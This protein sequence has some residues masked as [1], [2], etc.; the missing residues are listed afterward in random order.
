[1]TLNEWKARLTPVGILFLC[2]F[3][4]PFFAQLFMGASDNIYGGLTFSALI[5]AGLG[6]AVAYKLFSLK[7]L[8][9]LELSAWLKKF[10]QPQAKTDELAEKISLAAGFLIIVAIVWPPLGEIITYRQL[11]TLLKLGVLGYS[12]YLGYDIWKLAEPF[13]AYVQPAPPPEA[14]EALPAV[15]SARRCP[16]CGQPLPEAGE[17]CTFCGHQLNVGK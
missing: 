14:D 7:P 1:M 8:F 3:I 2:Y 13:L 10:A 16:K 9:K 5:Q 12:V 4:V 11:M 6:I 17:L 15:T